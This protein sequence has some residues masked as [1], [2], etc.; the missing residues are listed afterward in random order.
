MVIEKDNSVVEIYT[1]LHILCIGVLV[2]IKF[3]I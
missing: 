1:K 3:N 2:I